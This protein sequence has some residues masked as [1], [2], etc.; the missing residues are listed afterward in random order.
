MTSP[1][2]RELES[3]QGRV[4]EEFRGRF[5]QSPPIGIRDAHIMELLDTATKDAWEAALDA[6][7]RAIK[8]Q[9]GGHTAVHG[10][11]DCSE[12]EYENL[13]EKIEELK[14]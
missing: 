6:V 11:I 2:E 1:I 13:L 7:V 12:C 9:M 10:S 8:E 14:K 4:R 3:L 5:T